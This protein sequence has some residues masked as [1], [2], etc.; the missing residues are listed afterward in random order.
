MLCLGDAALASGGLIKANDTIILFI[1]DWINCE[2]LFV[3]EKNDPITMTSNLGEA[4]DNALD[5]LPADVE[6]KVG[7]PRVSRTF[8][9]Q[10]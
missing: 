6:L 4:F 7:A 8:H 2:S 10:L 9:Q 1:D 5:G 3:R